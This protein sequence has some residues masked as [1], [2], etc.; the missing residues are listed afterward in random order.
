VAFYV[1]GISTPEVHPEFPP[2]PGTL[3]HRGRGASRVSSTHNR[4]PDRRLSLATDLGIGVP[5]EHG[6]HSTLIA[7]RLGER[8]GVDPETASHTYFACLLFYVGCT[9]SP[10]YRGRLVGRGA[11]PLQHRLGEPSGSPLIRGPD[12]AS[13]YRR[14]RSRSRAYRLRIRPRQLVS[15]DHRDTAPSWA[16]R[17][18]PVRTSPS[19][20]V[21]RRRRTTNRH[22]AMSPSTSARRSARRSLPLADPHDSTI[23]GRRAKLD[24]MVGRAAGSGGNAGPAVP[25]GTDE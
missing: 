8:L 25:L 1:T 11:L 23:Q 21:A 13:Q 15:A 22:S 3:T 17:A 20:L 10:S 9:T 14:G 5:L 16:V 7:M 24:R 4:R 12:L 18:A 2:R 6:L 19:R